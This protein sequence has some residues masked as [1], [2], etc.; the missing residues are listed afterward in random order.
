RIYTV[1]STVSYK[2]ASHNQS[3]GILKLYENRGYIYDCNLK[4]I[5]NNTK[6]YIY[7]IN[8]YEADI[9]QILT[10]FKD[11]EDYIKNKFK[12]KS[13]FIMKSATPKFE[14]SED[15]PQ[16][17]K[18]ETGYKRYSGLCSHLI[19]YNGEN[20]GIVGIEQA[21]D[22]VLKENIQSKSLIFSKNAVGIMT[23]QNYEI[24]EKINKKGVVLTIDANLQKICEQAFLNNY[25]NGAVI[26][27]DCQTGEIKAS[28]SFPVYDQTNVGK[29]LNSKNSP[30]VNKAFANYDLGSVFKLCVCASAI[31][32]GISTNFTY[33][34]PGY[35][36]NADGSK[37]DCFNKNGHGIV[38][39]EKATEVSC[40]PYFIA[41]AKEI[42]AEKL[43]KTAESFGFGK[44]TEFTKGFGDK[45]GNLPSLKTLEDAGEFA[46]F[47]FGQ[48]GLLVTP[49][50]VAALISTIANGGNY[51]YPSI[52]KGISNVEGTQIDTFEKTPASTQIIKRTTASI[53]SDFMEKVVLKGS[54]T[55]AKS[56][57]F[58]SC[59]KTGSAETGWKTES[60]DMIVQGWFAGFF[61]YINLTQENQKKYAVV[62]LC[63]NGKSG[64]T[65]AAPIFKEISEKMFKDGYF[66]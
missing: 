48:G 11:D 63:E 56:E 13:P 21:F 19:G 34:C 64:A 46:N 22:S 37:I 23:S 4:P 8:P 62:V 60:G 18:E 41:L 29:S 57:L 27:M 30:L 16:G 44:Y 20:G 26:I 43:L 61:P 54:G 40:N 65:A 39:M 52:V 28:A 58:L 53:I 55:K 36:K 14:K 38:D 42:G 7:I 49:V 35:Y 47:G 3:T 9:Y 15:I 51:I 66:N 32:N 17:I 12:E 31:E 2:N 5:V 45:G 6:E 1:S 59:G 50:Q 24:D 10:F 33:D 25:D